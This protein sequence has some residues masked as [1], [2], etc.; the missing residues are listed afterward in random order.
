MTVTFNPD[1]QD[2][3]SYV[4]F[5]IG[6]TSSEGAYLQDETIEALYNEYGEYGKTILACIRFIITQLSQPNFRLDWLSVSNE[7]ARE[8]FE[9]MLAEKKIEFNVSMA[10]AT[11]TIHQ[12]HRA[13]SYENEGGV[14]QDADGE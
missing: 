6:D 2:D 10:T 1:L 12:P 7:Q 9:K 5:H 8:G 13:D 14:Y 11:S 3:V 4:R